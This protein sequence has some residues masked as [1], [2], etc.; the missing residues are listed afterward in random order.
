MTRIAA[1]RTKNS[2]TALWFDAGDLEINTG[3]KVVVETAR[4]I[5]F[6]ALDK[7]IF[8]ATEDQ[9]KVLNSELKSV[10]RIANDKDIKRAEEMEKKSK[11]AFPKFQEI[12][13]QTNE[14]MNPTSVEYLLDGKKAVFYFT[15]PERQDFRDLVKKLSSEFHLRVDMRQINEREKSALVGGIGFCGQELC[16]KRLGK[17]PSHVSIKQA[18]AQGMALNP[19][20]ISGMCGKLLCCLDYEYEDYKEFVDRAPKLKAR[21]LTPE[22]EANVIEINMPKEKVEVKLADSEKRVSVLLADMVIDK[23]FAKEISGADP[24]NVRPNKIPK[25]AWDKAQNENSGYSLESVYTST[26]LKGSEKLATGVVKTLPS[27]KKRA[28]KVIESEKPVKKKNNKR[29]NNKSTHN[30]KNVSSN[31]V[32]VY[33]SN[34]TTTVRR[35]SRKLNSGEVRPGQHS[36]GLNNK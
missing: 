28:T 32:N 23:K 5:E 8:E 34:N 17:C 24:A 30:Q 15:A 13:A 18:K 1:V 35:R 16:C 36:S 29:R 22:G 10:L 9:L 7:P 21:V 11:E 3:Q 25:E 6:G 2:S 19:E 12:A 31:K 27:T 33:D 26:N 4:G 20:N 14:Q